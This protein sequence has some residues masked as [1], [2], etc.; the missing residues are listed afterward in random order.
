MLEKKLHEELMRYK[1]INKYASKMIMEQEEPLPGG[2]VE[3]PTDP[4]AAPVDPAAPVDS[5]IPTDMA[6]P[7]DASMGG[8]EEPVMDD[9]TEEID[10]TDLVNMTKSIKNNMDDNK[11]EQSSVLNKMDDVF[12]KLTDL[13]M[14]L[15]QMDQVVAKIEE[16]GMKVQQMKPETPQEKLEMRSLDSY[17]FNQKPNQFFAQKQGEMQA[18]GK[19]E[20]V[21]TKQDVEDYSPDTIKSSFNPEEKEDEFKY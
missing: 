15:S 2:E 4:A 19:N 11:S 14:K 10:I 3:L 8:T 9:S 12:S 21:L 13:E 6:S 17:P 7:E 16:L 1:Q 5:S 20:Y 18:S